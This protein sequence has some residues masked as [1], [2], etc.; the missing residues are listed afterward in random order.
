MTGT[1][2][3]WQSQLVVNKPLGYRQLIREE[4][5]IDRR[6]LVDRLNED[7]LVTREQVVGQM[8][9]R[10]LKCGTVLTAKLIE[11][12]V[13]VKSGQLVSVTLT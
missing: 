3:A 10:E 12:T 11:A 6:T 4:D 7:P 5:L 9:G 13:L 1:L 8:A 2:R